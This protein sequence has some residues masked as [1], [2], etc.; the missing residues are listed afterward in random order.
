MEFSS[1]TSLFEI[2]VGISLASS[3]ID[4][5]SI[6]IYDQIISGRIDYRVYLYKETLSSYQKKLGHLNYQNIM[7]SSFL[8]IMNILE[9]MIE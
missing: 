9:L 2:F 4:N 6:K 8:F 5:F 7:K 3:L 1:L